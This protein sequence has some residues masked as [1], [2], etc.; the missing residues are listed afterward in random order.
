[1]KFLYREF[2]GNTNRAPFAQEVTYDLN[3]GEVIGFKAAR[4]RIM[5]ATNTE[6]QYQVLEPF[7]PDA[8]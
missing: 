2:S 4:F 5:K 8:R 1:M 3:E 7:A 6:I